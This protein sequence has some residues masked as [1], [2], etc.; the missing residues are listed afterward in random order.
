[1]QEALAIV[2]TMEL[3]KSKVNTIRASASITLAAG[4]KR[5]ALFNQKSS[6]TY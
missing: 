5:F 6:K 3:I 2:D 4:D 1:M